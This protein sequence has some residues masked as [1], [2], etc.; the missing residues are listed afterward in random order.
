MEK[1]IVKVRSELIK[2]CLEISKYKARKNLLEERRKSGY[3]SPEAWNK[4]REP[5][6]RELSE[7]IRSAKNSALSNVKVYLDLRIKEAE[8]KKLDPGSITDDIKLLNCGLPLKEKEVEDI[9][10]KNKG[11]YT[12]EQLILRY[13]EEHNMNLGYIYQSGAS[14]EAEQMQSLL[15]AADTFEKY[16][17]ADN[18]LKVLNEFLPLPEG[19]TDEL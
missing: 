18:Y 4:E 3:Y 6:L 8:N 10:L 15:F 5:E 7:K 17:E 1:A 14:E 11:N 12:M 9:L 2:G 19:E 13:A 16:M